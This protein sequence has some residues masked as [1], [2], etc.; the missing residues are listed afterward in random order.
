MSVEIDSIPEP[1]PVEEPARPEEREIKKIAEAI[2]RAKHPMI[3]SGGGVV[4]SDACEAL[5]RFAEKASIPVAVSLQGLT[6]FSHDHPLYMGLIGMHGNV[7]TN[8]A[9][10]EVDL[11]ICIGAR[12]NDR[13]T[14]NTG[15]FCP[16]ARV[17]H[18]DIDAS[19][20]GKIRQSDLSVTSDAEV[21]LEMLTGQVDETERHAWIERVNELKGIDN[22][23][24][25]LPPG[26]PVE[27]I[28]AVSKCAP[29]GSLVATDVG[30]HQ[31]WV[32]RTYPFPV[33]RT[34]FTSGGLGTMGFGLPAAIGAAIADR[35]K[36]V[37][38]FTGDGSLLMN[39]QELATLADLDLNVKVLILNNGQLGLVRQQQELFYDR[40]FIATSFRTRPDF[41][42][43]AAGF[44]LYSA[45]MQSGAMDNNELAALLNS[46][47]PCMINIDIIGEYNVYPM[48]PPGKENIY[49][50][51]EDLNG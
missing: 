50:I 31:M 13:T 11:L 18:A 8:M 41:S 36:T 16:S 46:P 35:S 24:E 14:G 49:M 22:I 27:V 33:G 6:A 32:A 3:Y 1:R 23:G 45:S 15:G 37:L 47:G 51:T 7:S 39:I 48:V 40:K 21:F 20:I 34:F 4:L 17:I 5:K 44:G 19:E 42:L 29:E 10:D 2:N 25:T 30:Q 28:R 43:I 9:M 38:C 12:F 26:H